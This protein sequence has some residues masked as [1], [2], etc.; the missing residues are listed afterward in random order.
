RVESRIRNLVGF[1]QDVDFETVA[2]RAIAGGLAQLANLVD[3]A[4][5]GRVNLDNIHRVPGAN[6]GTGLASPTGLGH[7][8]IGGAAIQGHGQNSRHGRLS[9]ATMA[10]A[11]LSFALP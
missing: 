8:L 9:N 1:I 5:G 4:V 10:A 7:G 11:A 2:R 3:S 6:F